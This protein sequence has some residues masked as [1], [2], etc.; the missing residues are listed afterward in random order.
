MIKVKKRKMTEK[1][2]FNSP[3]I[4]NTCGISLQQSVLRLPQIHICQEDV[5]VQDKDSKMEQLEK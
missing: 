4:N 1:L 5:T 3:S 2:K